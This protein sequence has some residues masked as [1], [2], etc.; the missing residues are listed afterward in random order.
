MKEKIEEALSY[1]YTADEQAP[2]L[3]EY[4]HQVLTWDDETRIAFMLAYQIWKDDK[5]D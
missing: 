3:I 4:A 5:N 1:M 2:G